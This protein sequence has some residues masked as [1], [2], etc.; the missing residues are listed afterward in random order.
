M[1]IRLWD[2][3]GVLFSNPKS[4]YSD[5]YLSQERITSKEELSN[6]G[7]HFSEKQK[8]ILLTGRGDFQKDKILLLLKDANYLF[9]DYHFFLRKQSHYP[10]HNKNLT[11]EQYMDMYY[12]FKR[13]KITEYIK[14]YGNKNIKVIDDDN[15]II[16]I[17]KA[18]NV[19]TK[20]IKINKKS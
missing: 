15:E 12:M 16:K 4:N 9:S 20:L 8:N 11:F 3:D 6:F 7:V 10:P 18:L 5:D 17:A 19:K 1:K 13:R 14:Y 2:F